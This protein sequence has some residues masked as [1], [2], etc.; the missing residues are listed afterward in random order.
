MDLLQTILNAQGGQAVDQ[1]GQQVGLDRD[2][3][4]S[5][6]ESL[7]PALAGGVARNASQPGGLDG[8]L[9]A[10]TSGGHSQYLDNPAVLR[11][12]ATVTDGNGILGHILG[13]NKDVSR[14]IAT[15]ASA[16][17][18][19]G[20]DVL[21]RLLPLVA[22]LAMGAMSKRV[23]Q[24][25]APGAPASAGGSLLDML[26]PMLDRNRDGSVADDVLGMLGKSFG[27]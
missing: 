4:V 12:P 13:T 9:G 7:L 19:I 16:Q 20:A 2:Q 15:R 26:A 5:A 27:R 3:T 22:S 1:L 24:S 6:I 21:K 25:A 17:T 18:G 10:L 14:Q 23:S 11:D 8:L